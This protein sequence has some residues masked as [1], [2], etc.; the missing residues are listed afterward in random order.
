LP[1]KIKN[2][3]DNVNKLK[4]GNVQKEDVKLLN[5][6]SEPLALELN[7]EIHKATLISHPLFHLLDFEFPSLARRISNKALAQVS[8][9]RDDVVFDTGIKADGLYFVRKGVLRYSIG[10]EK[11]STSVGR[12]DSASKR[13]NDEHGPVSRSNTL[14]TTV[15]TSEGRFVLLPSQI[16]SEAALWTDWVH[17]GSLRA[18][19]GTNL[20]KIDR[21]KFL[22]VCE[23]LP[24]SLPFLSEYAVKFVETLN[25]TDPSDLTTLQLVPQT[26]RSSTRRSFGSG[27]HRPRSR[28]GGHSLKALVA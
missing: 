26:S 3:I 15:Q 18:I 12:G 2:Y 17:V 8:F 6:L 1:K 27:H 7:H 22:E 28:A 19:T 4:G 20:V 11:M 9:A 25:A 23:H 21:K 16:V 14:A 5:L 10:G 24:E 13:W